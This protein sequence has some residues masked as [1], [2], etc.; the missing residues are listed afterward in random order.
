R[1]TVISPLDDPRRRLRLQGAGVEVVAGEQPWVDWLDRRR[2]H[3]TSLVSG[4][5]PEAWLRLVAESQ[6]GA[7]H[8]DLA[9]LARL[10]R[11]EGV[12]KVTS[13]R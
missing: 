13:R 12:P 1:F 6:P 10:P 4:P 3:Y 11:A 7:A 2:A 8:D 9:D 5:G